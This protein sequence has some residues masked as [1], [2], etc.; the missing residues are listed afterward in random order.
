MKC[1]FN[2]CIY[3]YDQQC[4]FGIPEINSSG[5]CED[6]IMVSIDKDFLEKE[7]ER[8]MKIIEGDD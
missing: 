3:N 7:K 6:C 1:E 4:V 8:Q 5:M 2:Y